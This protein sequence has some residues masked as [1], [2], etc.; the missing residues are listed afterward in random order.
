MEA[1]VET[2]TLGELRERI[3]A[4]AEAN[5]AADREIAAIL[6]LARDLQP[7]DRH[8]RAALFD[9]AEQ[10]GRCEQA[11]HG[12]LIQLLAQADRIA[13]RRGVLAPWVATHLDVCDGKARG[14]AQ[15]AT[16]IGAVPQL[17]EALSSGRV[18]AD[19]VKVLS[20]TVRALE[21]T[22]QDTTATLTEMLDT[23]Q[24]Q[25]AGAANQAVR[26]LEHALDPGS[27]QELLARQRARSFARIVELEDGRCRLEALLDP[28]RGTTLRAALD[29]C[30][31]AWIRAR[32]YD[33]TNPLPEDVRSTDQIN[34]QALVHVA[35]VFLAADP[36]AR[37][38]K[39]APAV[40][41]S[42]PLS[43]APGGLAESVYGT[44]VPTGALPAPGQP[45]THLLH[46]DADG[47]PVTLDGQCIDTDPHAQLASPMQRIALAH[48]DKH[49]THP[50][51]GRPATWGLHAHHRT[52]YSQG[53]RTTVRE[54]RLLCAEHHVVEH[55]PRE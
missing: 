2:D 23:A 48:R 45:G 53:G 54:M 28:V 43:E 26:R 20:R 37:G 36:Q 51:C 18:S 22:G 39:F 30:T 14:I 21:G 50:G 25:G 12:Q 34:A 55:H 44:L 35:E 5:A 46:V 17:S 42:A 33:K 49:C 15:A 10:V 4:L 9:A 19:T 24:Q 40:L 1:I 29:Q 7:G 41:Y 31:S 8:G 32:Q 47:E 6:N 3:V 11:R 16:R 13:A 27:S 52:P 38:V